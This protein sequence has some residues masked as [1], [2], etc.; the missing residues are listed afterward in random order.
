L[1]EK[2]VDTFKGDQARPIWD[3]WAKYEYTYGD[4]AASQKMEKRMLETY[5]AGTSLCLFFTLI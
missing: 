4:L 2:L 1:F 5:P 3:T